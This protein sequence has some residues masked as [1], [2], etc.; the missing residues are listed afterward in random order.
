MYLREKLDERNNLKTKIEELKNSIFNFDISE[1]KY[2]LL[3][4]ELLI[5]IDKLQNIT[6]IIDKINQQTVITIGNIE[7]PLVVAIEIRH[8]IKSKIDIITKLISSKVD[9]LDTLV[10]MQQRDDYLA[11]YTK[12]NNKIRLVDWRINV[13]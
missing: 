10:L 3:I 12:I 13:E 11:E 4:K 9:K 2:D 5:C 8:T 6:I 1:E 7:V